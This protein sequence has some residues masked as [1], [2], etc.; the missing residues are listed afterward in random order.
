MALPAGC[1]L[2]VAVDNFGAAGQVNLAELTMQLNGAQVP[3]HFSLNYIRSQSGKTGVRAEIR[4]GDRVLFQS[5]QHTML[6]NSSK[7]LQLILKKAIALDAPPLTGTTWEL[8][9]LDGASLPIQNNRPTLT[10]EPTTGRLAGFG[11]VN[12]FGGEYHA[13]PGQLQIDPGAS[14]LMAGDP[15]RMQVESRFMAMLPTVN[16]WAIFEG[17]LVLMRGEKELASFKKLSK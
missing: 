14:T 2:I 5:P 17:Q 12:R 11:G 8:V 10:F 4:D 7:D 6:S 16:R 3:I 1:R 9:S 15:E 13:S